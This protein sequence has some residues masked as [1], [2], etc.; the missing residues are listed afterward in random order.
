MVA[1]NFCTLSGRGSLTNMSSLLALAVAGFA[2]ST[3]A[4]DAYNRIEKAVDSLLSTDQPALF[5]WHLRSVKS[6]AKTELARVELGAAADGRH[7]SAN[8]EKEYTEFANAIATGLEQTCRNPDDYLK[9]GLRTLVLSRYS[10]IDG[11]PQWAMVQLPEGWD[12]KKAYPLNVGLHGTGPDHPM[13]YPS[14]TFPAGKTDAEPHRGS[15]NLTP[16]GRGN[17]GWQGDAETDMWEAIASLR[18]FATVDE[19]RWYLSGHSAGA[20]GAW[21]IALRTPDKWAAVGLQSGSMV[22]ARPELGLIEN[23]KHTPIYILIGENDNLRGRIP[24]SKLLHE[25]LDKQ[26]TPNKLNIM[27]GIGHYPLSPEGYADQDAWMKPMVRKRPDH[28]SFTV[29]SSQHPGVWG[30]S[31]A[32]DRFYDRTILSPFPKFE[33]SI[34]GQ[35][36]EIKASGTKD[37]RIVTGK[38]GL[39]L[40]GPVTVIVNG[41]T[42]FVDEASEAPITVKL[43]T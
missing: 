19:D 5:A 42:S 32:F 36:V 31:F 3:S 7:K 15:I 6:L 18:Q 17:R 21:A 29:D 38:G 30:V 39:G 35:T 16:W 24:D 33:V 27:K 37:L 25:M 40:K 10:T 1:G 43:G 22:A 14:Y 28:F 9:H 11:T 4:S 34:K 20:D 13:A 8:L 41:K 26:G 2:F 23:V 12:P